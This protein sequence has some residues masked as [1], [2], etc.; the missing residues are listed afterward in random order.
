MFVDH[1]A[2]GQETDVFD[3]LSFDLF[4]PHFNSESHFGFLGYVVVNTV[5]AYVVQQDDGRVKEAFLTVETGHIVVLVLVDV[6]AVSAVRHRGQTRLVDGPR[7]KFLRL[8]VQVPFLY[9]TDKW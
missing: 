9:R 6:D 2:T 8:R 7:K 1:F 3:N 5:S 4:V